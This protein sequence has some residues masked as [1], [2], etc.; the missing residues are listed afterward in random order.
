MKCPECGAEPYGAIHQ[1][2]CVKLRPDSEEITKLRA[3][4][5]HLKARYENALLGCDAVRDELRAALLQV[6]AIRMRCGR[7]C[8]ESSVALDKAVP[9]NEQNYW[10]ARLRCAQEIIAQL[11][12]S[13]KVTE[14]QVE[15][16]Q[17]CAHCGE[18]KADVQP[19]CAH[20]YMEV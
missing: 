7:I 9:G 8:D 20:C 5:E 18:A 6:D 11:I 10:G 12:D 17:K 13:G 16:L 2:T 1:M 14:K 4:V 15:P 19:C 3:E